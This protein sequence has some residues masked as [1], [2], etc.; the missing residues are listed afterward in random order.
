MAKKR[1]SKLFRGNTK[2]MLTKGVSLAS[3][4][5]KL[6][7]LEEFQSEDKSAREAEALIEE[8]RLQDEALQSKGQDLWGMA[9]DEE[10]SPIR[11]QLQA[12]TSES[13]QFIEDKISITEVDSAADSNQESLEIPFYDGDDITEHLR[14][15]YKSI[16]SIT[17]RNYTEN[18]D[19]NRQDLP[20]EDS[21]LDVNNLDDNSQ[22]RSKSLKIINILEASLPLEED[23]IDDVAIQRR[24]KRYRAREMENNRKDAFK[25]ILSRALLEISDENVDE[26]PDS[27]QI[28]STEVVS[29]EIENPNFENSPLDDKSSNSEHYIEENF[30]LDILDSDLFDYHHLSDVPPSQKQLAEKNKEPQESVSVSKKHLFVQID[31]DLR[32]E[33]SS[34][35]SNIDEIPDVIFSLDPFEDSTDGN[36]LEIEQ[37]ADGTNIALQMDSPVLD[38]FPQNNLEVTDPQINPLHDKDVPFSKKEEILKQQDQSQRET[39]NESHVSDLSSANVPEKKYFAQPLLPMDEDGIPS[40]IIEEWDFEDSEGGIENDSADHSEEY[41][42][43]KT[44]VDNLGSEEEPTVVSSSTSPRKSTG[45]ILYIREN[46]RDEDNTDGSIFAFEEEI[47]TD[48]IQV[49]LGHADETVLGEDAWNISVEK[50]E[51]LEPTIHE[52]ARPVPI[53]RLKSKR[54]QRRRQISTENFTPISKEELDDGTNPILESQRITIG[55]SS[56]KFPLFLITF[57]LGVLI[58]AFVAAC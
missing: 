27:N 58:F 10:A 25:E 39:N 18:N 21:L 15:R 17:E 28:K 29:L 20:F 24:E 9:E 6:D 33:D 48:G 57:I 46:E 19:N 37:D 32:E 50:D 55:Q 13:E 22:D 16:A 40:V 31:K 7:D 14:G 38:E 12:N 36:A 8:E 53:L 54:A 43:Q 34:P 49:N 1:K 42:A 11:I 2:K 56:S 26:N 5:P 23:D 30:G 44:E 35:D 41:Q 51:D 52:N 47:V 3:M 45:A 4:F